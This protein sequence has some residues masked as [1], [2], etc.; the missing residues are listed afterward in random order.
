MRRIG[1]LAII[2]AVTLAGPACAMPGNC[3]GKL[4][5]PLDRGGFSR[6]TD[7]SEY[8]DLKLEYLGQTTGKRKCEVYHYQYILPA[9]TGGPGHGGDRIFV[10]DRRNRYLGEYR[11]NDLFDRIW[12]KG[13][14]VHFAYPG[15]WGNV[16]KLDGPEP[17]KRAW[18]LGD[19]VDFGK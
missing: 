8:Y 11:C 5:W 18:F 13:S 10:F 16:L 1:L 9:V 6:G 3:W 19:T 4:K 15:K 2:A 12:L 7:C 14:T 17:P